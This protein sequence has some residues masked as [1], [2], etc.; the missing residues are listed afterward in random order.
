MGAAAALGAEPILA[1]D[2]DA[3]ARWLLEQ[4][5]K[6][7][8]VRVLG[9]MEDTNW[10]DLPNHLRQ[11]VL[12]GA[13]GFPC[14]AFSRMGKQLGS[15]DRRA[16]LGYWAIKEIL[17]WFPEM[18]TFLLEQVVEI[19][20]VE[21][22]Y[23]YHLMDTALNELGFALSTFEV[24]EVIGSDH[25]D[26]QARVRLMI[27]A[28][29][30][31]KCLRNAVGPVAPPAVG[32]LRRLMA[33]GCCHGEIAIGALGVLLDPSIRSFEDRGYISLTRTQPYLL[34][35]ELQCIMCC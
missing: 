29:K 20:L 26:A 12:A 23:M 19:T 6:A 18:L 1:S 7:T 21:N 17:P 2:S 13:A 4:R 5:F 28:K 22:G 27:L 15:H 10:A 8:R 33:I 9:A 35:T 14:A 24:F 11:K 32:A 25:G 16:W 30:N 34:C 3:T 31:L